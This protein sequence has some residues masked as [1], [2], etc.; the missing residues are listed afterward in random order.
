M[1]D[2]VTAGNGRT[3]NA[4][5]DWPLWQLPLWQKIAFFAFLA[6]CVAVGI[7]WLYVVVMVALF[8]I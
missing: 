8:G 7:F 3:P 4:W 5:D 2:G 1:R 6:V